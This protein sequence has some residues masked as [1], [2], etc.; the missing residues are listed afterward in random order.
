[1]RSNLKSRYNSRSLALVSL[2]GAVVFQYGGLA[3]AEN[4][5][6]ITL[7]DSTNKGDWSEVGKANWEM[8][9]GALNFVPRNRA[10]PLPR[11]F[12]VQVL[13]SSAEVMRHEY[14]D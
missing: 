1:M 5:G 6:W 8:K 14:G 2:I 10:A 13:P 11:A 3:S 7:V 4:D 12:L 9:D